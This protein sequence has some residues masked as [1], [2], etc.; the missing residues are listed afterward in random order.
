MRV[1]TI[2]PFSTRESG[3]VTKYL[4]TC[5]CGEKLPIEVAQAGQQV[6]CDCGRSIAVPALRAIRKL[7][8]AEVE[9]VRRKSPGKWTFAH[10]AAFAVGTVLVF[11]GF[12]IAAYGFLNCMQVNASL[13]ISPELGNWVSSID[14]A[15]MSDLWDEWIEV[16]K[17]LPAGLP[18]YAI[19]LNLYNG[20]MGMGRTGLILFAIG[21]VSIAASGLLGR[22]AS[23]RTGKAN[24]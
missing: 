24:R 8:Q 13:Q 20:L 7:P 23:A 19:G 17:G 21:V 2:G 6:R 3:F 22:R 1:A 14:Q 9:Q 18:N 4:L 10:G 5:E 12:V 15:K 16:S 11:V